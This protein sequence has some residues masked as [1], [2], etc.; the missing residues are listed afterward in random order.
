MFNKLLIKKFIF[1]KIYY[2][3]DILRTNLVEN[4]KKKNKEE[5]QKEKKRFNVNKLFLDF[6]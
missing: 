2:K 5:K 1:L 6:K 3:I 4:M